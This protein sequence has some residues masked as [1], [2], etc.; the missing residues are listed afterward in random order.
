MRV[1]QQGVDHLI[2]ARQ[3]VQVWFWP[4]CWWGLE[5]V[6][7]VVGKVSVLVMDEFGDSRRSRPSSVAMYND[8]LNA[9]A[10]YLAYPLLVIDINPKPSF[11]II[12]PVLIS[13]RRLQIRPT[14][15]SSCILFLQKTPRQI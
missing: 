2:H 6:W 7:C 13:E 12:V 10:D 9:I 4:A 1:V 11:P 15:S 3:G 8:R 5:Y 14:D